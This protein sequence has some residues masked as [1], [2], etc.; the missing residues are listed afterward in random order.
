MHEFRF[1]PVRLP[2]AAEAL[3]GEV[4]AFI[5]AE[6]AQGAF[7]PSRNSW[8]SFDPDFSRK[9]GERGYIGMRWPKQY[10]GHD[11][12]A[13]ERYVVTEEML[14]G[15]APVGAHWIADRQ[16]GQQIL[17]YGSDRAKR[18]I[19][20]KIAAGACFFSIG[21]SEPDSGSD[22][23]AVRTRAA[24]VEGGWNISG[25]KVWT[26]GAH[27]AN[28]LIALA[29]TSAKE[30][31][32]HAGMTQFIVD[33]SHPGVSV[34]PIYNLYGGHD[35]NE[36]VFDEFFVADDMVMGEAGTGWKL[37]TGELAFER[38]G[39]DRFLSTYQLLVESIRM[40]GPDPDERCA[41]EIG[42]FVAHLAT[43]RRMSVSVAGMLERGAQPIV[44]A[45]L[46]KDVGTAFE[47]EI[48]ETFR[49]LIPTEPTLGE[50]AGYA[51][52]L[53]MTILRAPGFTIRGGT[54]E[55]LRGM[56]ARGLGLR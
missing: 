18:T 52:L 36:V 42:R 14:A 10:G 15:G 13:L 26:S 21:M 11:R 30:E 39:P 7:T 32:R 1:E 31:D 53:G 25:T 45:A 49:H 23:A 27:Q 19:L 38:S 4:R 22:L 6:V 17:R 5:A 43:L 55:I 3:R 8:S 29:R 48:P 51:E 50:G 41:N 16:S 28:Y 35:F 54:R 9:C 44:E 20:P 33:L 12:S 40:I 47:R 37:V 56:I 46:V 34:R 2:A 24:R